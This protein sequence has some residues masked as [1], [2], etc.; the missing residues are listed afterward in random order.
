MCV[1]VWV[2]VKHMWSDQVD[3]FIEIDKSDLI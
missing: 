1:N 3:A 2:T